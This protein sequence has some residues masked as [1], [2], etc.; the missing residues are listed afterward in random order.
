M[1]TAINRTL[2]GKATKLYT[3]ILGEEERRKIAEFFAG[4]DALEVSLRSRERL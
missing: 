3:R 4:M 1:K 2:R